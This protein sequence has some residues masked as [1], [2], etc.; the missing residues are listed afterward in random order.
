MNRAKGTHGRGGNAHGKEYEG[1]RHGGGGSGKGK[2]RRASA[3]R[4]EKA[5][6]TV[7][8]RVAKVEIAEA[9]EESRADWEA[10]CLNRVAP[11]GG[12]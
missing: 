9:E 6:E 5:H 7:E 10:Y 12:E 1:R 8:R 2:R 3:S 11:L 4:V